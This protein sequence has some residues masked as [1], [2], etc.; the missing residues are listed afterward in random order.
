MKEINYNLYET[1]SSI[2]PVEAVFYPEKATLILNIN[3]N[4]PNIGLKKTEAE[5]LGLSN[6]EEF[7]FT[8]IGSNTGEDI[9]KSLE[10]LEEKDKIELL[11]K[12][13]Q[14]NESMNW[15]VNFKNEFYHV[16]KEYNDPDLDYPEK[17]IPEKL[18]SI[19]Q[20][21]KIDGLDEF[22]QKLNLLL[23]RQYETPMPHITLHTTSTREDKK[24]RGIGIYSEN[25]FEELGPK[26]I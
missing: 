11:T 13:N 25:Q 20:M 14:L 22:Y 15:Q 18:K 23:G 8:V 2:I 7:H 17:I 19:I 3:N 10:N 9:L 1:E 4:I 21:A 6:K 16:Q 5:E 26:K 24:L 12:I